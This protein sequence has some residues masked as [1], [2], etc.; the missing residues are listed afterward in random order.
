MTGLTVE[1]N[2]DDKRYELKNSEGVVISS[3]VT[4]GG[5]VAECRDNGLSEQDA[6]A[7]VAIAAK[8]AW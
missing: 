7:L 6:T 8:N 1:Y 2:S 3:R 4:P 5:M